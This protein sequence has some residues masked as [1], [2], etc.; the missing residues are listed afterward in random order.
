MKHKKDSTEVIVNQVPVF[1]TRKPA[2]VFGGL[3][4]TVARFLEVIDFRRWVEQSI[5]IIET[6]PNAKGIYS[7]VLGLLLTVL[8]GGKRFSHWVSWGHGIEVLRKAFGVEWLPGAVSVITRFF[9]KIDSQ[10]LA[11]QLAER[12]RVFA[13]RTVVWSE[14]EETDLNFDS[15]VLTRFGRQEGAKKGYNPKKPG[16]PSHHLL[17]AFLGSGQVLNLWNRSGDS[18]SAGGII[19]FFSQTFE[20]LSETF[21][22]RWVLCD[23][24][25]YL[26]E[27]L[28]FLEAFCFRYIIAVRLSRPLQR[29]LLRIRDWR[30]VDEGIEVAQFRFFHAT[31]RDKHERR[32]VAVR[33]QINRRPKA[34]GRQPFLLKELEEHRGYRYGVWVTN[35]EQT[36]PEQIWRAYR[37]RAK[38]ENVIKTLK[39]DFGLDGFCL[40]NFWATEAVLG[41]IAL[42]FYNLMHFLGQRVFA[43]QG[44]EP[45]LSTMR[46]KLLLLPAFLGRNGRRDVIRVAVKE[47][48]LQQ[49]LIYLYRKISSFSGRLNCN[50]V[51]PNS[52]EK[53][54]W[55]SG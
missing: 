15:S 19:D 43:P 24:G 5:P 39:D 49:R 33:Q 25:F 40:D 31:G 18:H 27:F 16:R 41:L 28:R 3:P 29:E 55:D 32:Y 12:L 13:W 11:E 54:P 52:V 23:S 50:A 9:A 46:R 34:A 35:D 1:F 42:V 45:T 22:V 10:A 21:R 36:S 2:T 53:S 48:S 37:P 8:A 51:I 6:S 20:S 44:P 30:K 4:L 38:D 7:K 14:V 26:L 47:R 17:L